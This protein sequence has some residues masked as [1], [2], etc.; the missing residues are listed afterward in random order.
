MREIGK[1]SGRIF[2][3]S[4]P[5]APTTDPDHTKEQ[6]GLS[7]HSLARQR[8]SGAH[9]LM[10]RKPPD[11]SATYLSRTKIPSHNTQKRQKKPLPKGKIHG[12]IFRLSAPGAPTTDPD[13]AK[14]QKGLSGHSLARQRVSG[15]RHTMPKET[16]NSSATYLQLY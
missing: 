12:C 11:S 4:V 13:H 15:A 10:P 8:V 2:R 16:P 14:E 7:G 1:N 9:Q 5:G 6:K 3:L